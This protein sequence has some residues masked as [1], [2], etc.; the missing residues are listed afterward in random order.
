MS[1]FH[2]VVCPQ[3]MIQENIKNLS[4]SF[5]LSDITHWSVTGVGEYSKNLTNSDLESE[6]E[7]QFYLRSDTNLAILP[8]SKES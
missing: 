1:L 8:S 2:K 7:K 4:F 6:L 3:I 5:A